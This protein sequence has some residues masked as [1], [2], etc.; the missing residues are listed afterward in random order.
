MFMKV[1]LN[2]VIMD[3][4]NMPVTTIHYINN[5]RN[6][7]PQKFCNIIYTRALL[8]RTT[9]DEDTM[10]YYALAQ[11]MYANSQE[12]ENIIEITV[13]EFKLCNELLQGEKLI[14]KARFLEMAKTLNPDMFG[15][16]GTMIKE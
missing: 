4:E 10:K 13:D 7:M 9:T 11:K 14:I 15:E 16:E 12:N 6:E 5:V 1:T 8:K 2:S 3:I